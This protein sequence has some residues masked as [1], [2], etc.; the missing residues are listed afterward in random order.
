MNLQLK[1]NQAVLLRRLRLEDMDNLSRYL[2][3]LSPQTKKRFGP[4]AYEK[5]SLEQL[6]AGNH[7]TG[8]A[9]V[10][11]PEET[12]VA[13]AIVKTGYLQHDK[14]RLESCGLHP[15]EKTDCT[16]APSVSD[17]WQG[18]GLG[19]AMLRFII[20]DLKASGINRIILWGGVQA[21]NKNAVAYYL[22][23][24]FTILGEFEYYGHN[25]DMIKVI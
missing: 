6:Y 8:Y 22:K 15:D 10:S 9:A 2:H 14:P 19:T 5:E 25:Y 24:G 12:I 18:C 23:N 4:H 1:N 20:A 17:D 21:A 7:Y 11:T 3:A 13:Y 16:F